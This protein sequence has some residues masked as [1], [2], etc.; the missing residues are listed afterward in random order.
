MGAVTKGEPMLIME[1]S[2]AGLLRFLVCVN[3]LALKHLL[4]A[5]ICSTWIMGTAN[6]ETSFIYSSPPVSF[7]FCFF[8][9]SLYDLLHNETMSIEG[10]LILPLL[11]DIT[12]VR[13]NPS[14]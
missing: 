8:H 4:N 13:W 5:T 12:Q 1:V 10:E 9:R 2:G 14:S 3:D 11:K 6:T 7:L